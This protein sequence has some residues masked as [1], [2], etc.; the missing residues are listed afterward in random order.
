MDCHAN[1]SACHLR[2]PDCRAHA[3]GCNAVTSGRAR[4]AVGRILKD[5]RKRIGLTWTESLSTV[6]LE[7]QPGSRCA[8]SAWAGFDTPTHIVEIASGQNFNEFTQQRIFK[9]LG[10]RETFFWPTSAQRAR[11]VGF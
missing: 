10:M 4:I 1:P 9:S 3:P 8:Y 6:P 2:S 11:L 5:G 7:F